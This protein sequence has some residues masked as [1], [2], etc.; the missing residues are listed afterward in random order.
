MSHH[1]MSR[2]GPR[3]YQAAQNSTNPVIQSAFQIR[4][5]AATDSLQQCVA[6]RFIQENMKVYGPGSGAAY[7]FNS[8]MM[9]NGPHVPQGYY[10]GCTYGGGI[11]TGAPFQ[12]YQ[13]TMKGRDGPWSG[14]VP[15]NPANYMVGS[16]SYQTYYKL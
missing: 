11:V 9:H 2:L 4:E 6:D 13:V 5:H 10:Q 3:E 12:G 16:P 7:A 15:W 8:V 1:P 14:T